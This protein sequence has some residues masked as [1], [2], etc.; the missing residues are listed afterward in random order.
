MTE[1]W[2]CCNACSLASYDVYHINLYL[3]IVALNLGF[4]ARFVWSIIVE[5]SYYR[6]WLVS[7]GFL[8]YRVTVNHNLGMKNLLVYALVEVI[9][10]ST[11]KHTLS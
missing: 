5:V 8:I 11:D 3:V 2:V 7:G 1:V 10:D 9:G 6:D 4:H